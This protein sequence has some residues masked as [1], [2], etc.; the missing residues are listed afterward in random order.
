MKDSSGFQIHLGQELAIALLDRV[1]I[2][3]LVFVAIAAFWLL[4]K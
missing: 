2:S 1:G 4:K 3:V